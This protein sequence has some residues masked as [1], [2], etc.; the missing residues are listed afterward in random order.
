M[1]MTRRVVGALAASAVCLSLAVVS[2]GAQAASK[3]SKVGP[4]KMACRRAPSQAG[5][6]ATADSVLQLGAPAPAFTATRLDCGTTTLS[7]IANGHVTFLNF[8]A[9]WCGPCNDEAPDLTRFYN[10]HRAG[11]V[12]GLGIDTADDVP[13]GNPTKFYAKYHWPFPSVWDAPETTNPLYANPVFEAHKKADKIWTAYETQPAVACIPTTFWLRK[14]GTIAVIN[15]GLMTRADME[16]DYK[17]AQMSQSALQQDPNYLAYEA[18]HA[19][20]MG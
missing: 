20:C 15:V 2:P 4:V 6:P 7:S 8:F 9:S 12:N 17:W 14:D 3:S 13:V 5:T 18:T 19:K 16:Q 11:G 10:A 1:R